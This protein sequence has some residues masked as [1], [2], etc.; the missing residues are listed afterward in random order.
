[1]DELKAK[2]GL[3]TESNLRKWIIKQGFGFVLARL[4]GG[5]QPALP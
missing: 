1:M 5:R 4:G 3:K 2:C